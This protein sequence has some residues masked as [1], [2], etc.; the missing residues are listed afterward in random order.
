VVAPVALVVSNRR[1]T[2]PPD[3]QVPTALMSPVVHP[4]TTPLTFPPDQPAP[5]L[6]AGPLVLT[7]AKSPTLAG[8]LVVCSAGGVPVDKPVAS[9]S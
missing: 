2:V 7:L 6:A 3:Q 4:V 8:V 9:L 5:T 1:L